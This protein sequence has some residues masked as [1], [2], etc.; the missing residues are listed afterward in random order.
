M[1]NVVKDVFGWMQIAIEMDREDE[2][3]GRMEEIHMKLLSAYCD[4]TGDNNGSTKATESSVTIK[5]DSSVL[6]ATASRVMSQP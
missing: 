6:S 5:T 2:H 4:C 3:C 1:R